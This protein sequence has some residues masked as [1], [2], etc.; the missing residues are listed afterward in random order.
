[1]AQRSSVWPARVRVNSA[2]RV[3]GR[4]SQRADRS[5]G[6]YSSSSLGVTRRYWHRAFSVS[7]CMPR[8]ARPDSWQEFAAPAHDAGLKDKI[9][10]AW[11]GRICGCLLGKPV[12][13]MRTPDM[14]ELLRNSGNF[15]LARYMTLEDGV[16]VYKD[17][18]GGVYHEV[19]T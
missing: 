7:N 4:P 18:S 3:S 13:G 15:P 11:L 16:F 6:R 12:E 17:L 2:R 19:R 9:R 1:M 14:H 8:A 10:G 5:K